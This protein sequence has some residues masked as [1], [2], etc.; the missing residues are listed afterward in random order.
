M[1][2][3]AFVDKY[4]PNATYITLLNA[5]L[6]VK[7]RKCFPE[8][9]ARESNELRDNQILLVIRGVSP[10]FSKVSVLL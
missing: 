7:P 3:L 5:E 6:F 9:F 8:E 1:R 2:L 4:F 10:D